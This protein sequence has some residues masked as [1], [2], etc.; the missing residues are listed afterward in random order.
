MV[1]YPDKKGIAYKSAIF[2][3]QTVLTQRNVGKRFLNFQ[4]VFQPG[5]LHAILKIPMDELSNIYTDATLFFGNQIN[6]IN[7]KLAVSKNYDEMIFH[8]ERFLTLLIGKK[9]TEL[10]PINKIAHLLTNTYDIQNIDWFAQKANLSYRQF[11]RAFKNNTGVAPKDFR[12]LVKLDW[13]YLLKNRN[14]KEEWLSI[15]LRS[16]FYDYQHLA[17][18]YKKFIGYLHT[19][20][21]NLEQQAPERH[22]GDF[23]H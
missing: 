3:Q 5:V 12:N 18:N 22:F 7:E 8:V 20:F 13:A 17:K 1:D 19:Q 9:E 2:G 21:Y 4:I 16:G 23:E 10:H 6:E 15:A 11:D 14:P